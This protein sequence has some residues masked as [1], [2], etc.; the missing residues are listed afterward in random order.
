MHGALAKALGDGADPDRQAWHW[1]SS[2]EGPDPAVAQ[3]L[4]DVG[5]RAERRG[6]HAAASAAYARAAELTS[7]ERLRAE[8]Q[9]A[10]ARN[11]WAAGDAARARAYLTQAREGTDDRVLRADIERLRGRIEVHL[12][13]ATDAHRIFVDAARSVAADDPT[14]ALEIASTAAVLRVFGPDSGARL[15]PAVILAALES[16][17]TP[18]IRALT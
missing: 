16:D 14:R 18:S 9:Y 4:L 6:G 3:A 1:A 11:A 5:V 17:T 13:S 15:D 8:R 7:D 2:V 10:A 12:G